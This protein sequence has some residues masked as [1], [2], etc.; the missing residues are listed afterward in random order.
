MTIGKGTFKF[1]CR[2]FCTCFRDASEEH[3]C[4]VR[5]HSFGTELAARR[6]TPGLHRAHAASVGEGKM[7][8][9]YRRATWLR[10]HATS[11]MPLLVT[12]VA[13][14]LEQGESVVGL[15]THRFERFTSEL[16]ACFERHGH[17][18]SRSSL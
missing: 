16:Q 7:S 2:F 9:H 17:G 14:G 11:L 6:F 4:G 10:R 8:A 1:L 15:D 18:D 13:E 12:R 3:A 5:L